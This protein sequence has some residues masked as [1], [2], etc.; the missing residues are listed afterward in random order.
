MLKD[1]KRNRILIDSQAAVMQEY[2]GISRYTSIIANGIKNDYDVFMPCIFLRS[3]YF[4]GFRGKRCFTVKNRFFV[5][6]IKILNSI[7]TC[8]FCFAHRIDV[9]HP[10]YY[11]P[12]ALSFVSKKTKIV[13]TVHDMIFEL[14][15][16]LF[17]RYNLIPWGRK[18]ILKRADRIVAV[19]ENTKNDLLSIYPW[20]DE[21]KIRVIYEG[22]FITKEEKKIDRIM[23]PEKYVLYI[24]EKGYYKNFRTLFEAIKI[25]MEYNQDLYLVCVGGGKAEIDK[26]YDRV[27]QINCSDSELNYLYSHAKCFVYPSKYE[28]FGIPIVEAMEKGCPVILA[29]TNVFREIAQDAALFFSVSEFEES[30]KALVERI[31]LLLNDDV[32]RN[33]MIEK[34]KKR[35]KFFSWDDMV[36]QINS[37]Y[38]EVI[39][40]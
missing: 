17:S 24:G 37:L 15:A 31:D 5:Y 35:A 7:Y 11:Y 23:I 14:F 13:V 21:K 8:F 30:V 32:L 9:Y 2:G 38:M 4:E 39:N 34:G 36:D 1:K 12:F 10:S 27:I 18:K 29:D 22:G 26:F 16:E 28:G 20:I 6:L 19:S 25:I 33:E 3:K 40:E